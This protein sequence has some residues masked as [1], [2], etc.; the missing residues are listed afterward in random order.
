MQTLRESFLDNLK[1]AQGLPPIPTPAQGDSDQALKLYSVRKA[2]HVV[3]VVYDSIKI[4]GIINAGD[5]L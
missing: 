4:L 2:M 3:Y 5:A 1:R